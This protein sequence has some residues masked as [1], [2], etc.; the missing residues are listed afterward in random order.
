MNPDSRSKMPA[1][2]VRDDTHLNWFPTDLCAYCY[3]CGGVST[4]IHGKCNRCN[5]AFSTVPSKIQKDVCGPFRRYAYPYPK[6][7][8]NKSA[9][10]REKASREIVF[11][12]REVQIGEDGRYILYVPDTGDKALEN[13]AILL[14]SVNR[15]EKLKGWN[16]SEIESE[17]FDAIERLKFVLFAVKENFILT[18]R[19]DWDHVFYLPE[20]TLCMRASGEDVEVGVISTKPP[21]GLVISCIRAD[22]EAE[23]KF[24]TAICVKIFGDN[25]YSYEQSG[26]EL[27]FMTRNKCFFRKTEGGLWVHAKG[28]ELFDRP[29]VP[30]LRSPNVGPRTLFL[31]KLKNLLIL[32]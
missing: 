8:S 9:G 22:V 16:L 10:E 5:I 14:N 31:S 4:F 18:R 12:N 26:L 17:D 30:F 19:T 29:E 20:Q 15:L 32:E 6:A 23:M 21:L 2:M 3:R 27:A 24:A 13:G 1:A 25:N 11:P 7:V 28:S